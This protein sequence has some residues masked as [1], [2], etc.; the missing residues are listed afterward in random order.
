MIQIDDDVQ[1]VANGLAEVDVHIRLRFSEGGGHFVVY[2]KDEGDEYVITTARELDQRI[3]RRVEKVVHDCRQPGYSFAGELEKVE[4]KA[5]AQQDHEAS[6]A[7]GPALEQLAH[8]MRKG[9]G[10][11]KQR[12]FIPA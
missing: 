5:Q 6:E 8:A 3:V 12:I 11:D 10:H 4:A 2:W 7:R 1:G 9:T